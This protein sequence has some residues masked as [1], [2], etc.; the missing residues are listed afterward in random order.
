MT[1]AHYSSRS[2]PGSSGATKYRGV[3]S[4]EPRKQRELPQVPVTGELVECPVCQGGVK[5]VFEVGGYDS[6]RKVIGAH[7]YGGS[8]ARGWTDRCPKSLE[9]L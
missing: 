5:L 3:S 1:R 2:G 9:A 4:R 8:P 6:G 7:K